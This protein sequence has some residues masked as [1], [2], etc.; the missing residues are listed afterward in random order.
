MA[1]HGFFGALDALFDFTNTGEIL[2]ELL[3]VTGGEPAGAAAVLC[4]GCEFAADA[5]ALVCNIIEDGTLLP[6][7]P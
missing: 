2:V 7:A 1:G 5:A 4:G 6:L 3:R